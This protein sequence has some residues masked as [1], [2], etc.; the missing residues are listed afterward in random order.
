MIHAQVAGSS[1]N[2]THHS[3][4]TRWCVSVDGVSGEL[5]VQAKCSAFVREFGTISHTSGIECGVT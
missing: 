5:K 2:V 1:D 4:P 3:F